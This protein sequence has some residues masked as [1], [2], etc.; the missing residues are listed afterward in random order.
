MWL[1][2][3]QFLRKHKVRIR[4]LWTAEVDSTFI[5]GILEQDHRIPSLLKV[6]ILPP[7][8]INHIGE[9]G[10]VFSFFANTPPKT[11]GFPFSPSKE[12]GIYA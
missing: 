12:A 1:M 10:T 4:Q 5:K 8:K 11:P 3:K 2:G 6:C 7:P 9:P